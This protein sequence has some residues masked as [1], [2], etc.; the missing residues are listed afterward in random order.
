MYIRIGSGQH[1]VCCAKKHELVMVLAQDGTVFHG[2]ACTIDERW[3]L[4]GLAVCGAGV[5]KFV[6][7]PWVVSK[8]RSALA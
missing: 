3:K 7:Y 1:R 6:R 2:T 5:C 4:R 8:Y